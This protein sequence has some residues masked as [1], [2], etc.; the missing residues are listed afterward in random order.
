MLHSESERSIDL[1][2]VA[3]EVYIFMNII[4]YVVKFD[5]VE[6]GCIFVKNMI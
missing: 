3:L 1:Y 2:F 4:L 6:R 5:R